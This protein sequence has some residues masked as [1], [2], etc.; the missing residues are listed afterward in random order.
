MTPRTASALSRVSCGAQSR[1]VRS[2]VRAARTQS[3][4]PLLATA[5]VLVTLALGLSGALRSATDGLTT[6]MTVASA[7]GAL[8][9]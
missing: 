6:S 7:P 5:L 1:L 3:S 2:N 8:G 9:R 4:V